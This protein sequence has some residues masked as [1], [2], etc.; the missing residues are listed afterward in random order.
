MAKAVLRGYIAY[1]LSETSREA[2]LERFPA[3]YARAI[4]SHITYRF[5]VPQETPLPP[6]PK[7][8]LV[9]GCANDQRGV[10][11]LV[12]SVDG[13]EERPQPLAGRFHITQSLADGRSAVE[14]NDVIKQGWRRLQEPV[15]VQVEPV[16]IAFEVR[17]QIGR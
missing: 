10:Q 16:W 15:A 17:R 11:A 9:I 12:V 1:K 13:A 5:D 6:V 7:S 4:C 14:S 8:V 3:A 2:L